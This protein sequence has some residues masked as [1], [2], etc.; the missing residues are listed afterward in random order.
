MPVAPDSGLA[1]TGVRGALEAVC[2][3]RAIVQY[4]THRIEPTDAGED[5]CDGER[6]A[7]VD[8]RLAEPA[9]GDELVAHDVFAAAAE[10]DAFAQACL[11]A[12]HRYNAAGIGAVCNT[13]NPDQVTVGGG[14][15]LNTA[16]VLLAGL[17]AYLEEYLF[18][19]RPRIRPTPL[20]DDVGLYGAAAIARARV[21]ATNVSAHSAADAPRAED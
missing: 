11:D 8:S 14:V 13:V 6:E 19:D 2:T 5:E 21:A 12:I 10:G 16:A 20:G 9:R 18:V 1:S 3:G 7:A 17:D 4:V 15:A